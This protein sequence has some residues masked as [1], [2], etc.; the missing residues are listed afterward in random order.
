VISVGRSITVPQWINIIKPRRK[1]P[2]Y[3]C[4][5]SQQLFVVPEELKPQNKAQ[6]VAEF[7]REENNRASDS[8]TKQKSRSHNS[9]DGY[10]FSTVTT[11]KVPLKDSTDEST[12]TPSMLAGQSMELQED[13]PSSQPLASFT[14]SAR[15]K[16]GGSLPAMHS[17][18]S[19]SA[20]KN[21]DTARPT[22][23][24]QPRHPNKPKVTPQKSYKG[25]T[26]SPKGQKQNPW[27]Y[28]PFD[29]G[30]SVAYSTRSKRSKS[31]PA[32]S[33]D[34][35]R[36]Q[37]LVD[38]YLALRNRQL[39]T[40][41]STPFECLPH[42]EPFEDGVSFTP[43]VSSEMDSSPCRP[44][45]R[46][47]QQPSSMLH[48][49]GDISKEDRLGLDGAGDARKRKSDASIA[50]ENTPTRSSKRKRGP[51]ESRNTSL[52]SGERPP[53]LPP[54]SAK[55]TNVVSRDNKVSS[56]IPRLEQ[57]ACNQPTMDVKGSQAQE[58]PMG[59]LKTS[60]AS[61]PQEPANKKQ[62]RHSGA[63]SA[64]ELSSLL[65]PHK[66]AI[67]VNTS[68]GASFAETSSTR[69]TRNFTARQ[70]K[71]ISELEAE[72]LQPNFTKVTAT[73]K[74]PALAITEAKGTTH[75]I[76]T[77]TP[78]QNPLETSRNKRSEPIPDT[79][80]SQTAKCR[81]AKGRFTKAKNPEQAV[82]KD[83]TRSQEGVEAS[84]TPESTTQETTKAQGQKR[85]PTQ[86]G[87]KA[88]EDQPNV[89][90]TAMPISYDNFWR[91]FGEPLEKPEVGS[92]MSTK[93]KLNIDPGIANAL[94]SK[95]HQRSHRGMNTPT[96]SS[97]TFAIPKDLE[98]PISSAHTI[99]SS[100]T[101]KYTA[102]TRS[103][104]SFR[105]VLT[106]TLA[107]PVPQIIADLPNPASREPLDPR[108]D[109][110]KSSRS[111]RPASGP[112]TLATT[113]S[114]SVP[115]SRQPTS[116][117]PKV[118]PMPG[119]RRSASGP[120][121]F[122]TSTPTGSLFSTAQA[123]RPPRPSNSADLAW[124]PNSLCA[125]SV[126]SY[127]TEKMSKKWSNKEYV[128][129]S[130]CAYRGTMAEKET[131][132]RASGILMGVRFVLGVGT[133]EGEDESGMKE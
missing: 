23:P 46:S 58:E 51:S 121:T 39:E 73:Y 111:R 26:P 19:R 129:Q 108:P 69:S 28:I 72:S 61:Q 48:E 31:I 105:K 65:T 103:T 82:S 36:G 76:T 6:I 59:P 117:S 1:L 97:A 41:P 75:K 91:N 55:R 94:N 85:M 81:T 112:I 7:E 14:P 131:P 113:P 35:L 66:L 116:S 126:V 45:T 89:E 64:R 80:E 43:G 33:P 114:A 109:P 118:V 37:E 15:L 52:G 16:R 101:M 34:N 132:F 10:Y 98:T 40:L 90:S 115:G 8:I 88:Q 78:V 13:P 79:D 4:A 11:R 17:S 54:K 71:V 44:S 67:G 27:E 53:I 29:A 42:P 20:M 92:S 63:M 87:T 12:P 70:E 68:F 57:E 125:D 86:S 60:R 77:Q 107:L 104:R 99:S 50:S 5:K 22:T 9:D 106:P 122:A 38:N 110:I 2:E 56:R 25:P 120:I 100:A 3:I 130:G 21:K 127:A 18:M 128:S 93:L 62:R 49:S 32:S 133:R 30:K 83:M 74:K 123:S 47:D 24:T 124:K 96:L 95:P 84:M 102:D 119:S